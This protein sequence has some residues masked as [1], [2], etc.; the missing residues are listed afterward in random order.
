M[1]KNE[2]NCFG[3]LDHVFPMG[4]EGLREVPPPCLECPDKTACLKAA[5]GTRAGIRFRG[6]ILDRHPAKGWGGRLK[7]WSEKKHLSRLMKDKS[8]KGN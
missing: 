5:L 8:G 3:V 7:R 1:R 4:K 6:E 2:K